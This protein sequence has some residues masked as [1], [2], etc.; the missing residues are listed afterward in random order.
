MG[1]WAQDSIGY[2]S[3]HHRSLTATATESRLA[4]LT[5]NARCQEPRMTLDQILDC[6]ERKRIRATYGAVGAVIGRPARGVGAALGKRR[7]RASWVVN[8]REPASPPITSR[9]RNIRTFIARPTSSR[10]ATSFGDCAPSYATATQ[11]AV[12]GRD[13]SLTSTGMRI[14]RSPTRPNRSLRSVSTDAPRAGSLL[15]SSHLEPSVAVL[16]RVSASWYRAQPNVSAYSLI[17]RSDCRMDDASENAIKRPGAY[18]ANPVGAAY[19]GH[20]HGPC[21]TPTIT[22]MPIDSA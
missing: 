16:S 15:R 7:Q 21:S 22:R 10:Q 5:S 12:C 9:L 13:S 8:A 6:L 3:A 11:Q 4:W 1:G 2:T 17:S 20:R 18:S 14:R 19:S